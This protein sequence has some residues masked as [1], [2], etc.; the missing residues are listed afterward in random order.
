MEKSDVINK[1]L[2]LGFEDIGFT[3]IEPFESQ[4]KILDSRKEEY[5]WTIEKGFDLRKGLDP[6]NILRDAK[7]I[8]VLVDVYFREAYP[9]R[10]EGYFGRCYLDDDRITRGQLYQRVKDFRIFLRENGI[11]SRAPFNIPHR[12]TAARAGLGTFGK[13]NFLYSRKAAS[14][15]SW[16]S[17]IPLLVDY[18][19]EPDEPTTTVGCPSWCKN[20]CIA[21]CPTGALRGPRNINPRKCISYLSYYQEGITPLELRE[22]LGTWVYGCDRCQEV[23]PRNRIWISYEKPHNKRVEAKMEDFDLRKLLHMDIEYYQKKI[24]PHM[25]YMPFNETWRWKMNVARA[26]GNSLDLKYVP[27]LIKAFKENEDDRVRGMIAWA[28]GKLGG[29]D[30][31][32]ALEKFLLGN[33]NENVREEV[34]QALE[35]Y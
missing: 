6:K 20:T 28:L 14:K 34:L 30:S 11:D 12:L 32:S 25:F 27:E 22:P 17:P 29:E 9:A 35:R 3:T 7:S 5:E 24:W 1:A 4:R 31:K 15:S 18:E 16:I 21:S 19:F 33:I 2:E 10:L 26:M 23:C 8:I 13:N